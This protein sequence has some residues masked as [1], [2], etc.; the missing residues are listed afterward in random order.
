MAYDGPMSGLRRVTWACWALAALGGCSL[1]PVQ[2]GAACE[3]SAQCAG[4]LACVEHKC[5]SDI[6][7]VADQSMVPDFGGPDG[8]L[9]GA[10]LGDGGALPGSDG[11]VS[12]T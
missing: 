2:A 1:E 8:S 7:S 11:A 9:D 5:T 12:A 6:K 4:G 10:A 3:R